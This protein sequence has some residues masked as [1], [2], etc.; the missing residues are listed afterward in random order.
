MS[1][2]G[3][4]YEHHQ[5]YMPDFG[6]P[7]SS[8]SLAGLNLRALLPVLFFQRMK[9]DKRH[10]VLGRKVFLSQERNK[11]IPKWGKFFL[12]TA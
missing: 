3:V 4:G 8:E 10:N 2:G 11:G 9:D 5:G 7:S 12:V 6:R 1:T